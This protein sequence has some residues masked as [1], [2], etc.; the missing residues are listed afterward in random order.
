LVPQILF[1]IYRMPTMLLVVVMES[2][3]FCWVFL[4]FHRHRIFD[5]T[6]L[7]LCESSTTIVLCAIPYAQYLFLDNSLMLFLC[8]LLL[9]LV[10][11]RVLE[12]IFVRCYLRP[13]FIS[14]LQ[15]IDSWQRGLPG[16]SSAGCY[17]LV[18]QYL[19]SSTK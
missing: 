12:N 14:V 7:S 18:A 11:F 16:F 17:I 10:V 8:G 19:C 3:P 13:F 1:P 6:P 4:L 2:C 9:K 15:S 5:S